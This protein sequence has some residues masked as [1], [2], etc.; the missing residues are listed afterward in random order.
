MMTKT[1]RKM[2]IRKVMSEKMR[3]KGEKRRMTLRPAGTAYRGLPSSPQLL[4]F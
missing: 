4:Y 1:M 3:K 2:L